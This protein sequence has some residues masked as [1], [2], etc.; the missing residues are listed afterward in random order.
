MTFKE[1]S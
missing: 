1:F